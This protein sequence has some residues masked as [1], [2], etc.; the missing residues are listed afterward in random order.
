MLDLVSSREAS[1]AQM[2]APV[3][4]YV[5][6]RGARLSRVRR[7]GLDSRTLVNALLQSHHH[8]RLQER[9]TAARS[10]AIASALLTHAHSAFPAS[11]FFLGSAI[12]QAAAIAPDARPLQPVFEA[13][14]WLARYLLA[15]EWAMLLPRYLIRSYRCAG[16]FCGVQ[17]ERFAKRVSAR[18]GASER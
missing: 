12:Q 5:Q 7:S 1:W 16:W 18:S 10:I 11:P 14:A 13:H 2:A 15:V 6:H 8:L 3:C 17:L 4:A 9:L